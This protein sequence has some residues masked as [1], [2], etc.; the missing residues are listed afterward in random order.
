[1]DYPCG[2]NAILKVLT[3]GKQNIGAERRCYSAD[4]EDLKKG[5]MS[6]GTQAA[7]WKLEKAKETD[8]SLEKQWS[9]IVMLVLAQKDPCFTS[10]LQNWKIINLCRFRPLCLWSFFK[11]AVIGK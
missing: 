2:F 10:D 4:F 6:Q 5:N 8:S 7:H 9:P 11:T 3:R 1:M